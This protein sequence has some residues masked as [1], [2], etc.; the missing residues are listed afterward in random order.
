MVTECLDYF[1]VRKP[2]S[3]SKPIIKNRHGIGDSS[4]PNDSLAEISNSANSQ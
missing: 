3:N 2:L 1:K 4:I